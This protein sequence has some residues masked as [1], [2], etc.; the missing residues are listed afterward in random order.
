MFV[1][2]LSIN[3]SILSRRI[4]IGIVGFG[5][6]GSANSKWNMSATVVETGSVPDLGLSNILIQMM[7]SPPC[8]SLLCEALITSIQL[9]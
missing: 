5:L 3:D 6:Y 1:Y 4:S 8:I 7:E 2:V 9:C